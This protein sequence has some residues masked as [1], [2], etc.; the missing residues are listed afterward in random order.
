VFEQGFHIDI[1]SIHKIIHRIGQ[2]DQFKGEYTWIS[3]KSNPKSIAAQREVALQQT[4]AATMRM[5]GNSIQDK[6][7]V[8]TLEAIRTPLRWKRNTDLTPEEQYVAGYYHSIEAITSN[9]KNI[10][11]NVSTL[12]RFHCLLFRFQILEYDACGKFNESNSTFFVTKKE[13]NSQNN[14]E[15]PDNSTRIKDQID[16]LFEWVNAALLKNEVHPVLITAVFLYEILAIQPYSKGNMRIASLFTNLLFLRTGYNFILHTSIFFFIEK[17]KVQFN[18][19]LT[20]TIENKKSSN[21]QLNDWILFFLDTVCEMIENLG[22]LPEY[23]KNI[24]QPLE[25]R[26]AHIFNFIVTNQPVRIKTVENHFS[27]YSN[28][29]IRKEIHFLLKEGRIEKQY[30]DGRGVYIEKKET[31][32]N[33][34][35]IKDT[36]T[37]T[38]IT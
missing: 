10:D 16:E 25:L 29:V 27:E 6:K 3:G 30:A 26:Q 20:N 22:F 14:E 37:L 33:K 5:E 21:E 7:V 13:E 18:S 36:S 17:N 31:S 19:I 34:K 12:H 2:I 38:I 1:S 23:K 15:K 28:S 11:I 8:S 24:Q 35:P 4:I 9:Y 32:M